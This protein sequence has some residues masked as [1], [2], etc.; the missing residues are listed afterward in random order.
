MLRDVKR[1]LERKPGGAQ[2]CGQKPK[3]S[4]VTDEVQM[5]MKI[6]V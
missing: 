3:V 6:V 1:M 5:F 2:S 4:E